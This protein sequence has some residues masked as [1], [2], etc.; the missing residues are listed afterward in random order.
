MN[1][2]YNVSDIS[3][4]KV[5][6]QDLSLFHM[7]SRSLTLHFDQLHSLISN[8]KIPF[9]LVGI[10][11]I[12][13]QKDTNFFTNV[14]INGYNLHAQLSKNHAGG[15]EIY[16]RGDI[17]YKVRDELNALE[18]DFESLWVDVNTSATKNM[19]CGC[20]YRH[21]NTDVEKF[22][23]YLD[24]V[25]SRAKIERKLVFLMGD[26]NI[27]LLNYDSNTATNKF[28]NFVVS[29]YLLPHI[30]HPTRIT[31][32]SST[33]IDNIFT[34]NTDYETISGNILT[35][36]TDHFPQLIIL[37][38]MSINYKSCSYYQYD[39]SNFDE[40]KLIDDVVSQP[41]TFSDPDIDVNRMIDN[42][43]D[44]LA[45]LI[46]RHAPLKKVSQK[47]LKLKSKPWINDK[48]QKLNK[49][50]DRFSRKFKRTRSK[51][52]EYLYKKFRN[53]VV[54]ENR[55]CKIN[56]FHS[57]FAKHHGNMKMLWSGIKS[58][59][60]P[61]KSGFYHVSSPK[62]SQ[63]NDANDPKKM[64][65][66]FD[67]FFVHISQ[68]INNEILKT[69][70][71]PSDY[72]RHYNEKSFFI[73]PF[74]A[75]EIETLINSL[76]VGK[77]VGP[78]S[79]PIK[80]LK[81]LC[82]YISHP[83]SEIVIKSFSTG[84]FPH[85]LKLAK[86]VPIHKKGSFDNPT[87]Y[88]PM[89]LLS[90]FSKLIE[91]LM[92]QRLYKSLELCNVLYSLQ[93]GFREKH[94]ANHALISMTEAIKSTI[95]NKRF[96]CGVFID[97]KNAFD[98]VNHDIVLKKLEHYGARGTAFDWFSS[99]LSN[100][101]QFVS[102][103]GQVSEELAINCGVPQ[104]SVLGPLLFLLYINDLPNASKVLSFYFFADDTNIYFESTNLLHLQKTMNKHLR[105]VKKWLD[106]NKLALN[107]DK[108]NFVLFHSPQVSITELIRLQFGKNKYIKKTM[109]NFLVFCLMST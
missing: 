80:L 37:K 18:D 3:K 51:N 10:T 9:D 7:N 64:A 98:T 34:N 20:I 89:S 36:I 78:C 100:R 93:L 55:K 101:E 63:G 97:L 75:T 103:N 28:L 6:N 108:T 52:D 13:Q 16:I 15:A 42:F 4:L 62:D 107:L 24:T 90:V 23:Q 33:I 17:D 60:C 30:L 105:Y 68:K 92:H 45:V 22:I 65:N 71:S 46:E 82:F 27:N 41:V 69:P 91:K 96:G 56:Y 48:I 79:I 50:R 73:S 2:H 106:A 86:V 74:S 1:S 104:G 77:S 83:F 5:A 43:H 76:K 19:L 11:E 58:I 47:N 72:L 59:V 102:V 70:K 53:R 49:Y 84:V 57:Y 109:S 61:K 35:L 94:S 25:F 54:A 66:L 85:K 81:I 39:Y 29:Q 44:S 32:H 8:L 38:K 67:K 21:P 88:R 95:D 99:Y 12:R 14:N 31:D 87:N 40:Q 26:L